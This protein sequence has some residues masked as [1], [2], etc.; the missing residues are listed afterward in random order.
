MLRPRQ[1]VLRRPAGYRYEDPECND[2]AGREVIFSNYDRK[3]YIEC[4]VRSRLSL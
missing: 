1:Q 2:L 4:R 3:Y